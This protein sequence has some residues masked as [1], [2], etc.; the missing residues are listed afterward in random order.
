VG[1]AFPHIPQCDVLV[2]SAVSQPSAA[3]ALQSPRPS[4]Q[5]KPQAPVT[6]VRIALARAGH[7]MPHVP[8]LSGSEPVATSQPF[9]ATP[10][11]SV[12]PAAQVHSQSRP[13]H[14]ETAPGGG[15]HSHPFPGL[16]S[17]SA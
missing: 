14:V 17:Q 2:S 6:H 12:N 7:T 13:L 9:V 1:Q 3:M 11:Q 10:S 8:Q 16:P 5:A 4:S 15:A